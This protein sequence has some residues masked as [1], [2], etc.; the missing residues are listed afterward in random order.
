MAEYIEHTCGECIHSEICEHLP[1]LTGW[2][3][4]NPAYCRAFKNANDAVPVVRCFECAIPHNK[5]TG[6]PKLG[7]LVTPPDFYC[8]YGERKEDNATD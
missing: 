2:D 7:G 6:C 5:W 4:L 1:T 8:G 3:A